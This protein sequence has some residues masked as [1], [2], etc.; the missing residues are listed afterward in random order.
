MSRDIGNS[1]LAIN[2]ITDEDYGKV[3]CLWLMQVQELEGLDSPDI[4]AWYGMTRGTPEY[5]GFVVTDDG[6]PVGYI[7]AYM[8]YEPAT[9]KKLVVARGLYVMRPLRGGVIANLLVGKMLEE[10]KARGGEV[11]YWPTMPGHKESARPLKNFEKIQVI[12]ARPI[13]GAMADLQSK[14][15]RENL[16]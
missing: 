1:M 15:A 12:W 14:Q 9:S 10:G 13:D 11:V 16:Q 5:F 4:N 7:D 3:L 6:M 2:P 8:N